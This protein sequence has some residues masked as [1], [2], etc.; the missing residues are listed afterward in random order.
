MT[1]TDNTNKLSIAIGIRMVLSG[2]S[3]GARLAPKTRRTIYKAANNANKNGFFIVLLYQNYFG[4]KKEN[5]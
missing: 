2:I 1:A 5:S 4:F 3:L